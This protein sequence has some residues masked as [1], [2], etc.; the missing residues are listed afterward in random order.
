MAISNGVATGSVR[1]DPSLLA[2]MSE[3]YPI[4]LRNVSF[5]YRRSETPVLKGVNLRVRQG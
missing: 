5:A 4:E 2:S 1:G 3:I